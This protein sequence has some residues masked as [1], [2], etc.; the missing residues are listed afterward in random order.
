M[1]RDWCKGRM[2]KLSLCGTIIH[3]T[4]FPV[5]RR[6]PQFVT[7]HTKHDSNGVII[8][9]IKQPHCVRRTFQNRVLLPSKRWTSIGS[10]NLILRTRLVWRSRLCQSYCKVG[11]EEWLVH[12]FGLRK[13]F[14]SVNSQIHQPVFQ[15]HHHP[16]R[17]DDF[18]YGAFSDQGNQRDQFPQTSSSTTTQSWANGSWSQAD[19]S[20]QSYCRCNG[21]RHSQDLW[22]PS[23]YHIW[24]WLFLT[25]KDHSEETDGHNWP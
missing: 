4:I 12:N 21:W 18:D 10:R 11:T 7:P 13:D 2:K 1:N 15:S 19:Q 8:S 6:S 23:E 20:W 22:E 5:D 24:R 17:E 14:G 3:T 9:E 16:Q 25:Q